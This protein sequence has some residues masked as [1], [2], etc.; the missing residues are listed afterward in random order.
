MDLDLYRQRMIQDLSNIN[1]LMSMIK[2]ANK[3]RNAALFNRR[4]SLPKFSIGSLV[5]LYT[6]VHCSAARFRTAKFSCVWKGSYRTKSQ[7][8]DTF[9]IAD[10]NNPD[11]ILSNIQATRLRKPSLEVRTLLLQSS[12]MSP[13]KHLKLETRPDRP[14]AYPVWQQ[15]DPTIKWNT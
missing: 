1:S 3:Q 14:G 7:P 6:T 4:R 12:Q 15:V 13:D 9:E 10:V 11:K 2:V 8:R 5:M